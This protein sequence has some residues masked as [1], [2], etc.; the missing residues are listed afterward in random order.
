MIS[1][2]SNNDIT[3]LRS[4]SEYEILINLKP[5]SIFTAAY[6]CMQNKYGLYVNI[7]G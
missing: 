2:I 4:D 5:N 7:S 6:T 3:T 1:G